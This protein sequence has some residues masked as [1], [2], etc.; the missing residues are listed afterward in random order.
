MTRS[1]PL[2]AR[3]VN[4]MLVAVT[5]PAIW[6]LWRGLFPSMYYME[7]DGFLAAIYWLGVAA[8]AFWG[9]AT[10]T[11]VVGVG[12]VAQLGCPRRQKLCFLIPAVITLLIA[13]RLP[14]L[15][16]FLT[17]WPGLTSLIE[18]VGP[19][20]ATA[21][22][23]PP[24]DA[25][26]ELAGGGATERLAD[27]QAFGVHSIDLKRTYRCHLPAGRL[28]QNEYDGENSIDL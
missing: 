4:L 25:Q 18:G 2:G 21:K 3:Y 26:K 28:H 23:R 24:W 27:F 13:L 6:L 19:M 9:A 16:G 5:L 8:V 17:A 22:R 10:S 11:V 1:Y 15:V 14:L 7:A 12:T 20:N